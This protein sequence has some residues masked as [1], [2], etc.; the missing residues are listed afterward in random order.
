MRVCWRQS[1]PRRRLDRIE[2]RFEREFGRHFEWVV[3]RF[4]FDRVV[5]S[6]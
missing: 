5:R 2:Q 1:E 6:E 4:R 3:D